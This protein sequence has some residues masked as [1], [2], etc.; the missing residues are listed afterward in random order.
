MS[1]GIWRGVHV[2]DEGETYLL[3]S[4]C[5]KKNPVTSVSDLAVPSDLLRRQI[6]QDLPF[7]GDL[8]DKPVRQTVMSL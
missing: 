7:L 1:G 4:N 6:Q 8:V 5:K 2:D 3:G